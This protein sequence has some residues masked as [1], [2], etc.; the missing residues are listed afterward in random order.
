[1]GK[2]RKSLRGRIIRRQI[3]QSYT[4]NDLIVERGAWGGL[5]LDRLIINADDDG[6][7]QS[8]AET[9]GSLCFSGLKRS[10]SAINQDLMAMETLGLI[11]LYEVKN[12]KY[13]LFPKWQEHQSKP[14][15]DRYFPS[16]LPLPPANVIAQLGDNWK[17]NWYPV[18]DESLPSRPRDSDPDSDSDSDPDSDT[19]VKAKTKTSRTP[20]KTA[21]ANGPHKQIVD[22]IYDTLKTRLRDEPV[23]PYGVMGKFL[24]AQLKHRDAA[25][26]MAVWDHWIESDDAWAKQHAWAW[27]QFQANFNAVELALKGGMPYGRGTGAKR[28]SNTLPSPDEDFVG[29]G[30]AIELPPPV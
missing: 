1:M 27:N 16:E 24:K 18:V 17:A 5:L 29:P 7:F 25:H 15:Q 20:R 9:V 23:L 13:G 4:V 10:R 21:A 30:G 3:C 14:Q 8:D 11:V 28:G 26:I 6:R 2:P 12:R 19:D 22:H